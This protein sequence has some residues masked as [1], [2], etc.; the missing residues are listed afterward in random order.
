MREIS[1]INFAHLYRKKVTFALGMHT[2]GIT[3]FLLNPLKNMVERLFRFLPLQKNCQIKSYSF[4]S[5]VST[6]IT[7]ECG[8]TRRFK[9]QDSWF[10]GHSYEAVEMTQRFLFQLGLAPAHSASK[11][12]GSGR[13]RFRPRPATSPTASAQTLPAWMWTPPEERGARGRSSTM[14]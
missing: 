7:V 11:T 4:W 14:A 13:P 12:G 2:C 3:F 9:F 5:S 6:Y 1:E 10:M 8:D